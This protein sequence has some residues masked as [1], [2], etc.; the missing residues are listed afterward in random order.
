MDLNVMLKSYKGNKIII[1][2]INEVTDYLST[3]PIYQ[4]NSEEI[5][6]CLDQ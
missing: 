4:S 6:K 5:G 1:C 3:V 2:I